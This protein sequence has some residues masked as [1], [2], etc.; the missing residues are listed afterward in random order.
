MDRDEDPIA[1][2]SAKAGQLLAAAMVSAESLAQLAQLRAQ[3]RAQDDERAAQALRARQRTQQAQDRLADVDQPLLQPADAALPID[4]ARDPAQ[5]QDWSA[6]PAAGVVALCYPE[7]QVIT[8][9]A[10]A[11]AATSDG[12]A[13]HL[14][15]AVPA[16]ER[17]VSS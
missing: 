14:V 8:G 16:A 13:A 11:V 2:A 17:T 4:V 15:T 1:H 3:K 5:P 12:A 10:V 7:A 6:P 9:E